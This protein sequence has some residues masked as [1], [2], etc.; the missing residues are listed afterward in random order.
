MKTLLSRSS[1]SLLFPLLFACTRVLAGDADAGDYEALPPGSDIG[2]LYYEHSHSNT[3]R[4]ANGH[5]VPGSARLDT[6][7]GILRYAHYTQIFGMTINPQILIPFGK[8]HDVKV[9]GAT[10]DGNEGIGDIQLAATLWLLNDP[11]KRRYFGI[12]PFIILPTGSYDKNDSL[13]LGENRWKGMLQAG[14]VQGLGE[15][16]TLDILGD[17]TWYGDNDR[18]NGQNQTLQQENTYTAYTWLRYHLDDSSHIALGYQ[19]A[20][21]GKQ[22]LDGIDNGT[23]THWDRVRVSYAKM[24]TPTFQ[25]LFTLSKDL[26]AEGG[27][28]RSYGIYMRF[29]KLF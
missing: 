25:G 28:E 21:G 20:W 22:E 6:D 19:K 8:I 9:G 29:L 13:N 15:K 27:F 24:F 7:I 16:F 23:R 3:Y 5:E 10:I 17:V 12:S 11:D 2:L 4:D 18:A 26:D 1:A 14:Y